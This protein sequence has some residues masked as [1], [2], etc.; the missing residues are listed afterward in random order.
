VNSPNY[1][2]A[3]PLGRSRLRRAAHRRTDEAWLGG[4]WLRSRV[5]VVDR[6]SALGTDER[7]LLIDP[8]EAPAGER[9]FLGED[10]DGTPYFAVLAPIADV[11]G[12]RRVSIR[13]VGH[14]LDDRDRAGQLACPAPVLA[15]RRLA[16]D[17]GGGGLGPGHR[18]WPYGVA[19]YR[20]GGHRP[21]A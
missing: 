2:P 5:L 7:L 13:D 15:V 21:G 1:S 20:S 10:E 9:I 17:D 12:T 3:P 11:P 8:S 4:A 14:L 18:E 16:D 19:P 6:E